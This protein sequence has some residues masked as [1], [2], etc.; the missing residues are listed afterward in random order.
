[1]TICYIFLY[2]VS[3]PTYCHVSRQCDSHTNVDVPYIYIYGLYKVIGW[4]SLL[5][6][7]D[8][9]GALLKM[10]NRLVEGKEPFEQSGPMGKGKRAKKRRPFLEEDDDV[11][12]SEVSYSKSK[13]H[14]FMKIHTQPHTKTN[15]YV[16]CCLFSGET[17]QKNKA[18]V[19]VIHRHYPKI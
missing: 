17:K 9:K 2:R 15:I 5:L 8:D 12:Q 3:L 14:N 4:I 1:M 10:R 6:P 11:E 13:H 7:I 18:R 16:C 19:I